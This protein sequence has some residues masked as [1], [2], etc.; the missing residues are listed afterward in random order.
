MI[1]IVGA[2]VILTLLCSTSVGV[3]SSTNTPDE[4][5]M[6]SDSMNTFLGDYTH[7][8]FVEVATSQACPPCH[9]W[10]NNIYNTYNSGDYD[11][12]YAEMIVYDHRWLILNSDAYQRMA[13][14]YGITAYPTSVFDGDYRRIVG[15]NPSQL[16]GVLDACGNRAVADIEAEISVTWLGNA[17]I[18][19]DISIQNNEATRYIGHIRAYVVEIISRYDT[20][21]GADYH[22]GFLDFAFDKDISIN[23][24]GIYTDTTTWNGNE[25]ADNHN[26]DFGDIT[27]D[28]VKVILAIFNDINGYVDETVAV[29]AMSI[30]G[31]C[32]GDGDV[33]HSDLGILLAAW[34]KCEGDEGYIPEADF[35]GSG[36][37]DHPDLGILLANWGYGT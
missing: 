10:N 34:G 24:G 25:H 19:V 22:N 31:D 28:N 11:F 12:E 35:D 26:D 6:S 20:Y 27:R 2:A 23:P 9:Y 16:P 21:Y 30:P 14:D 17:T 4:E 29:L 15:N 8:V 33:D 13:I 5:V 1:K 7:T 36:C 18:K 32:D 3:T 37:I